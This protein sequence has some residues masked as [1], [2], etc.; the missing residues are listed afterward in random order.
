[1]MGVGGRGGGGGEGEGHQTRSTGLHKTG[2]TGDVLLM[3]NAPMGAKR[4]RQT[5]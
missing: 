3:P 4:T 2:L 5:D 1:M